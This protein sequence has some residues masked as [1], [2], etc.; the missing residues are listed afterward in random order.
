MPKIEANGER[1]D[2]ETSAPILKQKYSIFLNGFNDD[3]NKE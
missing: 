1:I 2:Y 3:E